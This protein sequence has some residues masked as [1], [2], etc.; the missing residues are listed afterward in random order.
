M[1]DDYAAGVRRGQVFV[2]ESDT[3]VGL[4]VL[5]GSGDH[6]L[7]DNV[8]VH[9]DSQHQGVGR[10][11]LAHAERFASRL[12]LSELRLYT[13]AS[14]T[15]NIRLYRRLGYVQT[16]HFDQAGFDRVFFRKRIA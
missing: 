6:V 2:A 16:G 12:G 15:E 4:V 3:V 1:D 8:A 14:M 13:N 7:I 5:I 10:A 11:L 9:P